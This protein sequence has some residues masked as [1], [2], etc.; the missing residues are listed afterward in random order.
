MVAISLFSGCGG[1]DFGFEAAEYTIALRND[2]DKYS[3]ET[4]KMNSKHT[5]LEKAIED[6]TVEEIKTIV[7]SSSGAVDVV[8]GGPPCQPFSKS[9]YWSNGDTL[10][11]KDK[12]ANTLDEYF[13]IIK[14]TKPKVFLLENVHGINYSGKEE[15]FQFVINRIKN[16]N[17]TEGTNY[18]PH[19]KILNSMEY[20]VPQMRER[21]FLVAF[22]DGRMF[23]FPKTRYGNSS[24][25]GLFEDK[26]L[27]VITCW[28]A[29]G[30]I[31]PDM[32]EKLN[33]GGYW[34]DLLPSIPEGE[35]YLWHTD[36]KGGLPLFGWRTRYWC[37]L[38][39]LAKTK[40]SW[41]IQ[42][43][44]GS[45]IG[46]F[47]W[48]NRKL[49][50]REMA[51]IQTFPENFLISGSRSEIQRQIGNAVPSLLAEI[52]ARE[53]AAQ[54]FG[55]K[56]KYEPQLTIRKTNSIPKP[57]T[58]FEV[59]LKY[60][61]LIGEHLPHPGTGKGNSYKNKKQENTLSY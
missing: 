55:K 49:S 44:P 41:T 7:G 43:Q 38:L 20:G 10:R 59:P 29:I 22:K 9:A 21:F 34:A 25:N 58:V 57:E 31:K 37:F 46:P 18:I 11:L 32:D 8:I 60:Y 6:I 13:R 47:H 36:R 48:E 33:L 52:L 24:E 40:P 53:I 61:Y 12:R 4:L 19:W 2:N 30:H 1:L 51:A 35:N 50:W 28:D 16:I 15:G 14:E 26:K 39:K 42:A 45:A 17:A 5:V 56:Y 23:H 54:G 27:P 3:C